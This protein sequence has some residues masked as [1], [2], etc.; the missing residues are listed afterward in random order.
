MAKTPEFQ[1]GIGRNSNGKEEV[2]K[3]FSKQAIAVD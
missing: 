3:Q 1:N 2:A